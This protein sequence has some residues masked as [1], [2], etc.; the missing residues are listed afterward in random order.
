[1][2]AA[3][4]K[5][6]AQLSEPDGNFDEFRRAVMS[7]VHGGCCATPS[8]SVLRRKPAPP[9][10]SDTNFR[11]LGHDLWIQTLFPRKPIV[12]TVNAFVLP[13]VTVARYDR[14]DQEHVD[15]LVSRGHIDRIAP[16]G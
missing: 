4:S 3:L 14:P 7:L 8:L 6:G 9:M 10:R 11:R 16:V 5:N 1:M 2:T 15:V 13:D 12:P